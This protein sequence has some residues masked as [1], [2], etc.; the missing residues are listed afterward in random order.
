MG[1]SSKTK[2]HAETSKPPVDI[3]RVR[4]TDLGNTLIGLMEAVNKASDEVKALQ[5]LLD[6]ASKVWAETSSK[7]PSKTTSPEPVRKTSSKK[8]ETTVTTP[9][10]SIEV[11]TEIPTEVPT[12]VSTDTFLE[13]INTL[14]IPELIDKLKRANAKQNV[15]RNIINERK[16]LHFHLF[17]SLDDLI[18][19][20][21]GLARASLD[22]IMNE[23]S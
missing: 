17:E 3:L 9:E 11:P 6:T 5:P 21:K 22:K 18:L 4:I 14:S 8:Q 13:A 7:T 12:E 1:S 2:T 16:K 10:V 20:V 19:R 23:W 15:I